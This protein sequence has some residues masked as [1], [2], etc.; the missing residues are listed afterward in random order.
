MS[1]DRIRAQLTGYLDGE[2]AD[3]RGSVVRGHLRSCAACRTVANDEAALRD[4][5]RSLPSMDP[6][7]SLWAGVQQRLAEEEVADAERPAWRRALARWLPKA[8]QLALGGAVLA[9]ATVLLVMHARRSDDGDRTVSRPTTIA[10]VV[11][12]PQASAPVTGPSAP[13]PGESPDPNEDVSETLAKASGRVTDEYAKVA[14][15]LE[16]LAREARARWSSEQQREFD[17]RIAEHHTQIATAASARDRQRG[18][19]GLIRYL[20]RAAIRDEVALASIDRRDRVG[21]P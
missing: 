11:I 19:R 8:P 21:A 14:L 18:Y 4:G 2:L 3:D 6:P 7:A 5:L 13:T 17:A 1:C 20:Q 15:E 9:A 16:P 12:A 10:P